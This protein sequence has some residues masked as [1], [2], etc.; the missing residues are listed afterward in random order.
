MTLGVIHK[1]R[2]QKYQPKLTPSPLST[3]AQPLP[4]AGV[5]AWLSEPRILNM[6]T[7]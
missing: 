5:R 4:P 1:G 6:T 3:L 2:L 7:Q